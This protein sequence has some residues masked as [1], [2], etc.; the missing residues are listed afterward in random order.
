MT[1]PGELAPFFGFTEQKVQLL[2]ENYDMDFDEARAW[3]A[4]YELI[5]HRR[6]GDIHYAMYSP[7]S[8]VEAMLRH[9]FGTY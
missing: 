7:K 2:C 8:V 6:A 9:K 1:D 4:G 5:S 3:Y